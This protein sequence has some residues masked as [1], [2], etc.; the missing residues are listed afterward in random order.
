MGRSV[1]PAAPGGKLPAL[2]SWK[3]YQTERAT[4]DRI[5]HWW[6]H[7]PGFNV[8]I[9]TG[10]ISGVVIIDIDLRK[11]QAADTMAMIAATL[12]LPPTPEVVTAI[13]GIHLWYAHPGPGIRI[14]N[15]SNQFTSGFKT[16]GVDVRG[17]GGFAVC[18]PSVRPEGA[19][20]WCEWLCDLARLPPSLL[21]HLVERKPA[22][23]P[24]RAEQRRRSLPASGQVI[25]HGYVARAVEDEL[26]Q[27]E[28]EG[29]HGALTRSSYRLGQ[30]HHL[31]G[32][33]D[34]QVEQLIEQLAD[35]ALVNAGGVKSKTAALKTA[36][37]C[38]DA[39]KTKPRE[40][41]R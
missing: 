40:P 11:P 25:G 21:E 26:R 16:P 13:G 37:E 30:L 32:M 38:F 29:G 9:V 23:A 31:A 8:G 20:S 39:G 6:N 1:I 19:Y 36:R 3:R 18:P 41:S 10:A 34:A 35:A 24:T 12:D 7:T 15:S 14:P 28:Q 2:P 22:A 4:P 27:L 5:H 17:D 33:N